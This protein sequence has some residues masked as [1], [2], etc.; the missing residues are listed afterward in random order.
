LSI[1]AGRD[2]LGVL[3]QVE[4]IGDAR[5]GHG[6]SVG[7]FADGKI[8]FLE[9]FKDAAAGRVAEGFKEKIQCLYN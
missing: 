7:N 3:Q 2:E 9:H 8:A 4:V 6:E 1:L 5:S